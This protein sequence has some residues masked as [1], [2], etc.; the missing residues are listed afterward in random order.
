M[1]AG[2]LCKGKPC[3]KQ[4]GTIGFKLADRDRTPD[5]VDSLVL[6][7]GPAGKSSIVL[8]AKGANLAPPALPLGQDPALTIQL[9]NTAG[10][11]F[12]A[13]FAAPAQQNDGAQFR[14][15]TP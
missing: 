5:G 7:S 4:L 13:T 3:W 10:A 15:K 9:R 6:R 14:D 2:G 8:T 1:P 12:G 11:C